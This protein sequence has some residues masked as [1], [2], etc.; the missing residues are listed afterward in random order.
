MEKQVELQ[1]AR[2][3]VMRHVLQG[4]VLGS[5]VDWAADDDLK[6]TVL[7]LGQT[8]EACVV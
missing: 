8:N 3:D 6:D 5:G 7:S 2:V 4:L 1:E